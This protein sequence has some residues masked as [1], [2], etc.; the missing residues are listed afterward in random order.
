[1]LVIGGY[2]SANTRHLAA[3]CAAAGAETH[4]IE[5]AAELDSS[6]FTGRGRI[7]VTAG[8]STPDQIIDEVLAKLR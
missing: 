5:T 2:H 8:A 1:M 7:G 4:H 3:A 6:W